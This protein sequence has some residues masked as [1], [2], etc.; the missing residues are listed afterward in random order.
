MRKVIET[1]LHAI[2]SGQ[3]EV[4]EQ[5]LHPAV[6]YRRPGRPVIS[7][8]DRVMD[9]YRTGR[10]AL[11]SHI[12]IDEVLVDGDKAVALGLVEGRTREGAPIKEQFA[13]SYRFEDGLIRDRTTYFFRHGF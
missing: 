8:R 7:G 11:T 5:C 6:T 1:A 2:E 13:D 10:A 4:L 12:L 9:Y 3:H